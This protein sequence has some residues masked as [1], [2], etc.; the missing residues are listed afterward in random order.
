MKVQLV[1]F[2]RESKQLE[3]SLLLY[4]FISYPVKTSVCVCAPML[5]RRMKKGKDELS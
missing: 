1:S 5:H 4:A 2:E 3:K